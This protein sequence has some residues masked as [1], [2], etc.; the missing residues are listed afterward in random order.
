MPGRARDSPLRRTDPVAR[1]P[2]PR[3]A[4]RR[5][6]A[7]RLHAVDAGLRSADVADGVQED[8]HRQGPYRRR[9][10]ARRRHRRGRIPDG[11]P[12]AALHRAE[13]RDR[14]AGH[15]CAGRG[16]GDHGVRIDAMPV[17]RAPCV[18]GAARP[19]GGP[20]P[21]GAERNRRRL[22][23]QGRVP[24]DDRRA[25][26]A[27][28]EEVRARGETDLRPGRGHGRDHQASSGD[29]PPQD[30]SD[31]RRPADGDRDRR[32]V[33]RRRLRDAQRGRAVAR[34]D[35]RQRPVSLR[36]HPHPRAR[37]DDQHA[38]QRRVPR[39]RCAA[40]PV[41]R[42][43]AHRSHRRGARARP[44]PGPGDQRAAAR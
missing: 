19:A 34:R 5:R 35:P 4:A 43:S 17:L 24:V 10:R 37:G 39:L 27:A 11:A 42:R 2:G 23:R 29:R 38:A 18:D 28:G 33:R 8:R 22:R 26:G 9:L 41:R 14:D 3:D 15:R 30:R 36:S 6:R 12:G 31:A 25:R 40:D 7:D 13:R 16:R 20:G 32:R 21:G 1:A 44:G